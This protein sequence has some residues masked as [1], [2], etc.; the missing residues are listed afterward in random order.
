LQKQLTSYLV[1]SR[2][3]TPTKTIAEVLEQQFSD[4]SF[5]LKPTG[6]TVIVFV[7]VFV[8]TTVF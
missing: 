8:K 5:A 7:I 1:S 3:G 4:C 6:E 2:L